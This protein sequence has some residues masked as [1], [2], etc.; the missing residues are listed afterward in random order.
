MISVQDS[1]PQ[2]KKVLCLHGFATTK[3]FMSYQTR[4]WQ[5]KF[6][7]EF[8]LIFYDGKY[9]V[10]VER[11]DP[12]LAKWFTDRNLKPKSHFDATPEGS[13]LYQSIPKDKDLPIEYRDEVF[14]KLI[15]VLNE[16]KDIEG[17]LG[18]SQGGFL[19]SCFFQYLEKGLFKNVLKV[20]KLPHFAIF[21]CGWSGFGTTIIKAKSL[22]FIGTM[23]NV[24]NMAE[25]TLIRFRKPKVF[26]FQEGHKFPILNRKIRSTVK[27]FLKKTNEEQYRQLIEYDFIRPKL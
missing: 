9:D 2:R 4:E 15:R 14:D 22:H 27:D 13:I 20:D 19:V 7:K 8:E 3:E 25:L 17:L 10:P 5:K 26:F 11:I 24:Y 6:S 1:K 16:H 18:F 23:D 12:F 21:V